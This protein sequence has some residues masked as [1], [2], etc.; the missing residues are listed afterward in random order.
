MTIRLMTALAATGTL[1]LS[2]SGVVMAQEQFNDAA[3]QD[4]WWAARQEFGPDDSAGAIQ[5]IGQEDVMGAV[6]LIKQGKTATLGKLYA[7]DIPMVGARN[8]KPHDS[9]VR[10]VAGRSAGAPSSTMST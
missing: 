5:R 4:D 1:L 6:E 9:S 3:L 10:P 8:W 2:A 7:N